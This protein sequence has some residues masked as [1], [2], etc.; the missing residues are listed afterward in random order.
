MI[1]AGKCL[2]MAQTDAG[3]TNVKLA[4]DLGRIPQDIVKW[5]ARKDMKLTLAV[6]LCE[7]FDLTLDEFV[8]YGRVK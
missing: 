5:R 6:R 8:A 2:R 1:D 4:A 3:V 7:Y